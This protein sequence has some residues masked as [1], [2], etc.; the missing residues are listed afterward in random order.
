MTWPKFIFFDENIFF[1]ISLSVFF[2]SLPFVL[3]FISLGYFL[4]AL[5]FVIVV[6]FLVCVLNFVPSFALVVVV[7]VVAAAVAGGDRGGGGGGSGC[8]DV[9][10]TCRFSLVFFFVSFSF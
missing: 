3:S 10:H 9:M 4:C 2:P 6:Y 8:F 5:L 7:V 1:F